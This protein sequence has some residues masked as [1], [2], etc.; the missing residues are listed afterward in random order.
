MTK[1]LTK[2]EIAAL[3]EVEGG[4]DVWG[5]G[6]A[7]NLRSVEKK[8]PELLK[9]CRAKARLAGHLRQPY[10]G[11]VATVEG[12]KFLAQHSNATQRRSRAP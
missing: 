12:R 6:I 2:H 10:F 5:Y 4:A 1:R 11:A 9:I 7:V 3:R 8:R